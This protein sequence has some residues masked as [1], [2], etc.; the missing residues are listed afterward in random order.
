LAQCL[1]TLCWGGSALPWFVS[2]SSSKIG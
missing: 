1:P 2:N